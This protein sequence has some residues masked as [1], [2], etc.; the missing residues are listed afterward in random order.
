MHTVMEI[1][2]SIPFMHRVQRYEMNRVKSR[3]KELEGLQ[4]RLV[5]MLLA[6]Q[7]FT[8]EHGLTFFLVGGSAL[9]AYRHQGFIPWDDDA[10]IVFTRKRKIAAIPSL[11][12]R[13]IFIC[14]GLRDGRS[15][16]EKC[17]QSASGMFLK[18]NRATEEL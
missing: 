9:G 16:G 13:S 1:R 17:L 6:F 12:S 7:T 18:G 11:H 4:Q 2:S 3:M 10:D 5:E 14:P 15:K 8:D